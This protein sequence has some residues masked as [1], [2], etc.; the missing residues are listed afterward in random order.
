ML[1]N[2][3][4]ASV[5]EEYCHN[6]STFSEG[7]FSSL[8]PSRLSFFIEYG[9]S[10]LHPI[11]QADLLCRQQFTFLYS[12]CQVTQV[13]E[14]RTL[15]ISLGRVKECLSRQARHPDKQVVSLVDCREGKCKGKAADARSRTYP[16]NV[17]FTNI[18]DKIL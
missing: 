6:G 8:H 10:I 5:A 14:D 16:W 15:I 7:I 2:K 3:S 1:N 13:T 11:F 18:C 12:I 9:C 17:F 4:V